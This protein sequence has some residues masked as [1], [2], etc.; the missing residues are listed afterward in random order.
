MDITRLTLTVNE[1]AKLLGISR[2][3][4]YEAVARGEI[5]SIRIGKRLL[6]PRAGLEKLLT[7]TVQYDSRENGRLHS[8]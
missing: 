6:V 5:Y 2:N 1:T 4:C 3:S 8:P 7:G